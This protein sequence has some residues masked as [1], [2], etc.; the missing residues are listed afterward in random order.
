MIEEVRDYFLSC[1]AIKRRAKIFGINNLGPDALD[2]TVESVP[3]NPIVK[4]YTNGA[5]IRAK[6]FVIASRELHSVDVRRRVCMGRGAERRGQLSEDQRGAAPRSRRQFLRLSAGR[7]RKD[8]ALSNPSPVKLFYGGIHMKQVI[9]NMIADYLKPADSEGFV[10]M[11]TGFNTLD[12]SP[13]AQTDEK[14]YINQASS[15]TSIKGYKPEFSFD[16]DFIEDEAAI[17]D[18]YA[19]GRNRLTGEDAQREY[20]RVEL[21]KTKDTKGYPAR[22]F[23]V[24]VEVSDLATGDGGEVTNVSGT[25]HQIGEFVEGFFDTQT[26]TFTAA[27]A[28]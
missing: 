10:L 27:N 15:S 19:I 17:A 20:V 13:N 3:G 1:P 21:F 5:A 16:S 4:R 24:S 6:Q 11:G 18:L 9:R 23:T 2:Y 28:G 12:E 8:G 22:K 25:L 26:K 14:T 7:R